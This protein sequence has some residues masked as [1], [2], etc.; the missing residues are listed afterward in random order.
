MDEYCTRVGRAAKG[1]LPT[2]RFKAYLSFGSVAG[3]R[4]AGGG[5][6]HTP[7]GTLVFANQAELGSGATAPLNEG[8]D[9]GVV[10]QA[11]GVWTGT[12]P[13][14]G[15]DLNC[16]GW[17]TSDPNT[18]GAYGLSNVDGVAW[19]HITVQVCST[20]ARVYCLEVP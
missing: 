1:A 3:S 18:R 14:G 11:P 19:Q 17:S 20:P 10:P 13:G 5:P 2:S 12:N 7:Q 6:W 9:G 8:P 15:L 4:F 16:D